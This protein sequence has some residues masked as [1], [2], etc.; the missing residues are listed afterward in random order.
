MTPLM[1]AR[2]Q[3]LLRTVTGSTF[4]EDDRS[5]GSMPRWRMVRITP[6]TPARMDISSYLRASPAS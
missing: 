6:L 1:G 3:R 5:F 2:S 4:E